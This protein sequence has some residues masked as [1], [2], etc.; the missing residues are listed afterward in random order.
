M[1]VVMPVIGSTKSQ[2]PPL[3]KLRRPGLKHTEPDS[4]NARHRST[5]IGPTQVGTELGT[6]VGQM[7]WWLNECSTRLIDRV[8]GMRDKSGVIKP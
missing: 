5:L 4:S 3:H 6:A 8:G 1:Q 7:S 2:V